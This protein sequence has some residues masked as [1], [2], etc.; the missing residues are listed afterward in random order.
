MLRVS[1]ECGEGHRGLGH[2]GW[3]GTG[4]VNVFSGAQNGK[5][6]GDVSGLVPALIQSG[7]GII[8]SGAVVATIGGSNEVGRLGRVPRVGLTG[9]EVGLL[10][11]GEEHRDRDGSEDPEDDDHDQELDQGKASLIPLYFVKLLEPLGEK[12]KHT[13]SLSVDCLRSASTY[14]LPSA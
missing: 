5:R 7:L 9:G 10:P 12:L 8:T 3:A 2:A 14:V 4:D 1:V 6:R 13:L 11:L